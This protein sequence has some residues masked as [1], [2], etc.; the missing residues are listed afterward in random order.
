MITTLIVCAALAA[1]GGGGSDAAPDPAALQLAT[2]STSAPATANGV[3]G[4]TVAVTSGAAAAAAAVAPLPAADAAITAPVVR[5][6]AAAVTTTADLAATSAA[7]WPFAQP[8]LSILRASPKKVF[9][10]YFTPFPVSID[11]KAPEADYYAIHYL[12]ASGESGKFAGSGGFI[13]Q[14]PLPRAVIAG[15]DWART[16]AA[17]DVRRA[18]ALGIDGFAVDLLATS[19]TH[20]IRARQMMDVAASIDSGFKILLMPDMEAEFKTQPGNVL[21]AVRALATHSA[22]HRLPDGRLVLAPYNSQNQSVAWWNTL[23]AT[24]K[25]EGIDVAFFPVFQGWQRYAASYAPIS[26][27]MSDWGDRS[28]GINLGSAAAPS[29]ARRFGMQW[30]ST[31]SPQ[32]T[33]PKDLLYWEARNSENYRVM[34]EGA[35]SGGADWVQ[36]VTWNDYSESTEIAPSSGTQWSFYDLTAYYVAWFKT[37]VR[38]AVTRD[39]LMYFHRNQATTATA[40]ADKQTRPY[41]RMSGSDAPADDIEVLVYATAPAT[42]QISVGPRLLG[43]QAVPAGVTP[44]RVPLAEGTPVFRLVRD[45]ATVAA[46]QSG[47]AISNAITYQDLLYRG[48]SSLRDLVAPR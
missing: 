38:P 27:G 31:V 3:G 14:R 47:F 22:A 2:A 25:A 12:Q 4:A 37:G 41:S 17:Q 32:D 23:L 34:W 39:A 48:G 8:A 46:V 13:K 1:C 40:A 11:N 36:I 26:F 35:I 16:D 42:V 20:W 43:S 33:R 44:V 45:N 10:H 9:A 30:M 28:P 15:A 21:N 7:A 5:T 19:G 24:L 18:A 6:T 29:A